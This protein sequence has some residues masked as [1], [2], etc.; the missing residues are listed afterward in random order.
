MIQSVIFCEKW[1]RLISVIAYKA[2][3]KNIYEDGKETSSVYKDFE[4]LKELDLKAISKERID[5][6]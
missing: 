6:L 1:V 5:V 3:N 2:V 4:K